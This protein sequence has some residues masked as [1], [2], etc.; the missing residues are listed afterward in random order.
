M[1][2][3]PTIDVWAMGVILYFLIY[4]IL[5]FRGTEKEMIKSIT[6]KN[7]EF[8]KSR[9]KTSKSCI[10]LIAGLLARNPKN[11]TK[12]VDIYADEWFTMPYHETI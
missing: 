1:N 5:P 6:T 8:P 10:K 3:D 4:G 7:V 2:A 12:V 11:R 9:K